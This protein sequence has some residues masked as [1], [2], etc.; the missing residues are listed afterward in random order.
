VVTVNT[1]RELLLEKKHLWAG[2]EGTLLTG[3]L[4]EIFNV[5]GGSGY[6]VKAVAKSSPA[7]AAGILGGDR[8]VIINGQELAVRGDIILE[9][10]GIRFDSMDDIYRVVHGLRLARRK[11]HPAHGQGAMRSYWSFGA[12]LSQDSGQL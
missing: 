1:A 9:M 4:A 11:D 8:T 10:P 2:L 6:L 7:W 5:P 12:T 3:E